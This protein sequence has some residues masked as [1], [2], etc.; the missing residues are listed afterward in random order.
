LFIEDNEKL[1][2]I[3]CCKL[4]RNRIAGGRN[5]VNTPSDLAG[6]DHDRRRSGYVAAC[7]LDARRD[8]E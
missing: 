3:D 1:P 6:I 4:S 8:Q 5:A 2:N 7:P